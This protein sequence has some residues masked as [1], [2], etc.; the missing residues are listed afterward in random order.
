ME[1]PI[2]KLQ[3]G[4]AITV[5]VPASKSL[6][7]RALLL[8][9]FCRGDLFL[10]MGA[11][12]QDTLSLLDCLRQ[13]GVTVEPRRGGLFVRGGDLADTGAVNVGNAGTVARFLTAMLA[14]RGGTYRV[15]ACSQ[16]A[17]R[18]MGIVESLSKAGVRFELPPH[19]IF[20][21]TMSSDGKIREMTVD[22][23]VSTQYASGILL[24][25]AAG[26][27]PFRL[28]LT[29]KRTSGSYIAMTLA[30]I[31]KFGATWT[32]NA[33]T[34]DVTPI[35]HPPT[36][37]EVEPDVS[38]AC[39]FYALA[40]LLQKK[41]TV[42]GVHADSLQG[43]MNFI[44]LLAEKGVALEETPQGLIADGSDVQS[45]SGFDAVLTDF[46]DQALT[47]AALAPFASSPSVL[48]GI[49][50]IRKQECDRISAIMQNLT[51]LGVPCRAEGDDVWIAPSAIRDGVI[52]TFDDHRVAMAFALIGLKT[53]RIA[54]RNPQ[55]CAKTFANYFEILAS[56][57]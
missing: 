20:P 52:E 33:N 24:A 6:A 43:D 23:D 53:G 5:E 57:R 12:G 2:R 22:T 10:R 38:A 26:K 41:V 14:F 17:Q 37:Y 31:A 36:E 54:I 29:G 35:E 28:H 55:C 42:C 8:A 40:P 9:A 25:A 45:Y 51:A 19:G 13:L 15:D 27:E 47:V 16:M 30:L 44:R 46:S 7:N 1:L 39:Y 48:R 4:G 11:C 18:P 56:L 3:P 34:I 50:H 32:R 49:G 21:F